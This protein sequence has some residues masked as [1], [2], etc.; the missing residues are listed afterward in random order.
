MIYRLSAIAVAVTLAGCGGSQPPIAAP[1][2]TLQTSLIGM[3]STRTGS[4]M[5]PHAKTIKKLLYISNDYPGQVLVYNYKTDAL[6]GT[7]SGFQSPSGQCVDANG[8]VWIADTESGIVSEYA[9]GG[10]TMIGSVK[11]IQP[12]GCA[13]SPNG[14]LAISAASTGVSDEIEV[15]KSASG[16]PTVYASHACTFLLTP[17]Y[18]NRGN[19]IV[20]GENTTTGPWEPCV[21]MAGSSSLVAATLNSSLLTGGGAAWDGQHIVLAAVRSRVSTKLLRVAIASSGSINVVGTTTLTSDP[22][23]KNFGAAVELPFVVGDKNTPLNR[24]LGKV[25]LGGDDCPQSRFGFWRY[26]SGGEPF[27]AFGSRLAEPFGSSVSI[28]D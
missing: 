5:E 28:A 6:V 16:Q 11:A 4:R 20:E 10:T 25:L 21:L 24:K 12:I 14:D 7:I 9:H 13:I 3:R 1:Y 27:K 8:D 15:W 19:L 2:A 22:N 17:A 26:P 18:D 23:C